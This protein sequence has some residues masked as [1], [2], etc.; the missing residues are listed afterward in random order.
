ML[1]IRIAPWCLVAHALLRDP[2][3]L[4]VVVRKGY[5][6]DCCRE[7]PYE[8]ALAHLYGP[9]PH[10]AVG[11]ARDEEV[12]LRWWAVSEAH[13]QEEGMGGEAQ[14]SI[15][16]AVMSVVGTE[17]LRCERTRHLMMW[18][19]EQEIAPLSP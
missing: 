7:I 12:R 5:P 10:L 9:Q 14:S 17:A 13:W 19:L 3:N 2:R 1:K 8:E 6:L 11:R 16:R 18:S 4:L 15:V